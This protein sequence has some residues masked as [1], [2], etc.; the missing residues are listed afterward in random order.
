MLQHLYRRCRVRR[1]VVRLE[2]YMS[3]EVKLNFPQLHAE[4]DIEIS[5]VLKTKRK[6]IFLD[7]VVFTNKTMLM[8]EY[9]AKGVNISIDRSK[10]SNGYWS[11][12]AAISTDNK[13]EH[14]FFE[15]GAINMVLFNKFLKQLRRKVG[16]GR[17]FLF[18]D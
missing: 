2:K 4:L 10:L 6:I 7:E 18:M 16:K 11:V 5:R 8:R 14:L 9:S 12:I 17:V 15:Q 13:I 1:K 3:Q